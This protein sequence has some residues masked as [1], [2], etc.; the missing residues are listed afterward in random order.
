[1][2]LPKCSG[3]VSRFLSQ[4]K[5]LTLLASGG[6]VVKFEIRA[7]FSYRPLVFHFDGV[8]LYL[9]IA[10][11]STR[12]SGWIYYVL[13]AQICVHTRPMCCWVIGRWQCIRRLMT[14]PTVI[15]TCNKRAVTKPRLVSQAAIST[16]CS[17]LPQIGITKIALYEE[18]L[19]IA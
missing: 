7:Y 15:D 14:V 5:T 11:C 6:R 10:L 2:T 9:Y 1:M 17:Q 13:S 16:S 3:N 4:K 19:I 12:M 8:L 18:D